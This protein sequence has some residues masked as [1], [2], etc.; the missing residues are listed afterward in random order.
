MELYSWPLGANRGIEI[1]R[2]RLEKQLDTLLQE[3]RAEQVKC[4]NDIALLNKEL[5][6]WFKEYCDLAQRVRLILP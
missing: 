5:R 2:I 4:W 6:N 3:K 1:R